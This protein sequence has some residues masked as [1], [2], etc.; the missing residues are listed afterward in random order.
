MNGELLITYQ[1]QTQRFVLVSNDSAA[2]Y[3][4]ATKYSSGGSVSTVGMLYDQA[5]G[6][7]QAQSFVASHRVP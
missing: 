1:G 5:T 6:L 3:F 2:R 7:V 4:K